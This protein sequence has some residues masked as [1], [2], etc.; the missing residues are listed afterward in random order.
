M[1]LISV[2]EQ[3]QHGCVLGYDSGVDVCPQCLRLYLKAHKLQDQKQ[4][5][6]SKETIIRR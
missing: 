2:P 6:K 4:N 3:I 5:L 1:R